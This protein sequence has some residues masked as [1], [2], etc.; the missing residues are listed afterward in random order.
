MG[1]PMLLELVLPLAGV[2][3]DYL[4]HP[5][6]NLTHRKNDLLQRTGR[7]LGTKGKHTAGLQ[8][9]ELTVAVPVESC[10]LT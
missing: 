4:C 7:E 2:G 10:S 5:N 9:Q 3:R 6:G 8:E 1:G